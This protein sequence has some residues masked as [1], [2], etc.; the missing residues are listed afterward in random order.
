V[1]EL[2]GAAGNPCA[3]YRY[4]PR[5]NPQGVGPG[6]PKALPEAQS[7]GARLRALHVSPAASQLPHDYARR[8]AIVVAGERPRLI[9]KVPRFGPICRNKPTITAYSRVG[10]SARRRAI[11]PLENR[12][13]ARSQGFESLPLR[14]AA[15]PLTS[16]IWVAE[17][18]SAIVKIMI[19]AVGELVAIAPTARGSGGERSAAER[20]A[21][22]G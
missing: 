18:W 7:G 3:A 13:A 6:D 22:S 10:E 8:Q 21:E 20:S 5:G 19:C 4:D 9:T 2:L 14:L 12:Q 1:V 15:P 16:G 17:V 11:A